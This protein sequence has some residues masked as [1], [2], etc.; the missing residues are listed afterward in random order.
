MECPLS[1]V[2]LRPGGGLRTRGIQRRAHGTVPTG[3]ASVLETTPFWWP[4]DRFARRLLSPPP[5]QTPLAPCTPVPNPP[6]LARRKGPVRGGAAVTPTRAWWVPGGARG[7]ACIISVSARWPARW[8]DSRPRL[9]ARAPTPALHDL[10][11]ITLIRGFKARLSASKVAGRPYL[12]ASRFG[13]SCEQLRSAWHV[14]SAQGTQSW[15]RLKGTG[16]GGGTGGRP[17]DGRFSHELSP[18]RKIPTESQSTGTGATCQGPC[19]PHRKVVC[20]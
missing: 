2:A 13:L 14:L 15:T 6:A 4:G 1:T 8:P 3:P 17:T 18:V 11:G 10:L 9:Q 5:E 12:V 20:A 19:R 16:R 7:Q